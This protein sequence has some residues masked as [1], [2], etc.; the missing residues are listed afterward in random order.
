VVITMSGSIGVAQGSWFAI[1]GEQ[2]SGPGRSSRA[3]AA[4]PLWWTNVLVAEL[5]A[6]LSAPSTVRRL[7][8]TALAEWRIAPDL[9]PDT[10]LLRS[11]LVSNA[12]QATA[13]LPEVMPIG[14]RVLANAERLVIEAWDSHP[15]YPVR[16]PASDSTE[17]GRGLQIVH[18]LSNRWGSRRVSARLKAVWAELLIPR[19]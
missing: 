4:Y 13:V 1:G 6:G 7:A 19:G 16:Q 8:R 9:I 17:S 12:V 18:D 10:E 11:E 14:L 3:D 15:G 5:G 2:V